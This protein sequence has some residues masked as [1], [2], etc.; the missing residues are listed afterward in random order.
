MLYKRVAIRLTDWENR[1]TETNY[2]DARAQ[3]IFIFNFINTFSSFFYIAFAK[4]YDGGCYLA[5]EQVEW[6]AAF[7]AARCPGVVSFLENTTDG[8]WPKGVQV[9]EVTTDTYAGDC[10]DELMLQLAIIFA[11]NLFLET[12]W[13]LSCHI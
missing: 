4:I 5:C 2:E 6:G 12:R 3:K 10:M 1:E 7:D 11:A 13:R 9:A 8:I